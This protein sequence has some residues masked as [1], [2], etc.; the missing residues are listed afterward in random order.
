LVGFGLVLYQD[1]GVVD[2]RT[3][4]GSV[5]IASESP[6]EVGNQFPTCQILDRVERLDVESLVGTPYEF[7]LEIGAF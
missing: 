2:P 1:F 7:L 3:S 4:A 5:F 6:V